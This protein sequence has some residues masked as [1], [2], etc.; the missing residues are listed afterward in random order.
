[1]RSLLVL[2]ENKVSITGIIANT[3]TRFVPLFLAIIQ[4]RHIFIPRHIFI[5]FDTVETA[6][7]AGVPVLLAL[8]GATTALLVH[9]CA[10]TVIR[11][12]S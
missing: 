12:A 2:D 11:I 10:P 8:V 3:V 5:G 1:M 6:G 9:A 4:L 7:R